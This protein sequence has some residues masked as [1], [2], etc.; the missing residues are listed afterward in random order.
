MDQIKLDKAK[1]DL[2]ELRGVIAGD[3]ERT[4]ETSSE[5]F[6]K[7]MPDMNDEASRTMS[8]RILLEIGDKSHGILEKIDDALERMEE[9]EY[10][11]CQ[12]CEEDI[13]EKRLELLPY[14]S[15]CVECQEKIET[16]EAD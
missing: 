7:D 1:S 8:R 11:M 14:A 6:G 3:Y 9:G 10:G 5:E 12:E 4:V 13:P 15:Y 16:R 2:I